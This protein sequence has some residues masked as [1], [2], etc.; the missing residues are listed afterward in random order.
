MKP[1]MHLY[2]LLVL[3]VMLLSL[4]ACGKKDTA[5]DTAAAA[6]TAAADTVAADTQ[7]TSTTSDTTSDSAAAPTNVP[8]VYSPEDAVALVLEKS[9]PGATAYI[10]TA[11]AIETN[12]EY[13]SYFVIVVKDSYGMEICK[14]AV[15]GV[16]GELHHYVSGKTF[17]DFSQSPLFEP[18]RDTPLVWEGTFIGDESTLTTTKNE[19]ESLTFTFSDGTTGTGIITGNVVSVLTEGDTPQTI[20]LLCNI[21]GTMTVG[22]TNISLNGTYTP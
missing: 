17:E 7:D 15:D 21:D 22:G 16:S 9:P 20:V 2:A 14:V 6:D 13:H 3:L 11:F 8:S 1:K 19:D 5:S 10:S 18:K 4:T 12:N